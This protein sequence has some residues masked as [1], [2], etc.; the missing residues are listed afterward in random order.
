MQNLI[1]KYIFVQL[2]F[3]SSFLHSLELSAVLSSDVN[4]SNNISSE[5]TDTEDSVSQSLGLKVVLLE[6]RKRFNADANFNLVEQHYYDD[7]FENQTSL[8]TGV[9]IFNFDLIENF[10]NWRTSFTRTQVLKSVFDNDT[11]DNNE[12][13]NI[14]RSGPSVSYRVSPES[15]LGVSGNYVN[16]EISD[17][18]ASDSERVDGSIVY[19][20]QFN[21]TT[22]FDISG[23]YDE[24][25][26][27]DGTAELN[28]TKLSVGL[29]REL[30]RGQFTFNYGRTESNSSIA[31]TVTGNFF[32]VSLSKNQVLG[33]NLGFRYSEDLSDTSIG[34]EADLDIPVFL[35]GV[36]TGLTVPLA[37]T[38][39]FLDIVK[40]RRFN[41]S[42]SRVIGS[43]M[44]S[45][46]GYLR[47]TRYEVSNDDSKGRGLGASLRKNIVANF[48]MGVSYSFNLSDYVDRPLFGKERTAS[49]IYDVSYGVVKDINLSGSL[50]YEIRMNSA[51]QAREY[52]EFSVVLG[53]GWAL[54]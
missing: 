42:A 51:N 27:G 29:S 39:S 3:G 6:Q 18:Q 37:V 38:G 10:L 20:Y 23:R 24:I 17:P 8:T 45:L 47:D 48:A 1:K 12:S 11:P 40:Q 53:V 21:S 30:S 2:L 49:Y 26:D 5:S 7:T 54:M 52:E 35:D 46:S 13:R 15:T 28:N 25:I 34:F 32:D 14:L 4:Y 22:G 16:V 43:Y 33:H 31:D 19:N 50:K 36:D 44:Y 41:V 9:G